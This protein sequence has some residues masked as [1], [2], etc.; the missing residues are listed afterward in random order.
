MELFARH[1]SSLVHS[2]KYWS[3]PQSREMEG[4][5]TPSF[6]GDA[7][8]LLAGKNTQTSLQLVSSGVLRRVEALMASCA[9]KARSIFPKDHG[10]GQPQRGRLRAQDVWTPTVPGLGGQEV[11]ALGA[12]QCCVHWGAPVWLSSAPKFLL[13]KLVFWD[14]LG[15]KT[16]SLCHTHPFS[17]G[18]EQTI[19]Y[20]LPWGVL[21]LSSF[22]NPVILT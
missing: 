13:L 4:W 21:M 12:W 19:S 15:N 14:H 16:V 7:A 20:Q 2:S 9:E 17:K 11:R 5:G 3:A 8:L 6:V 1:F 18:A 22:V 10:A